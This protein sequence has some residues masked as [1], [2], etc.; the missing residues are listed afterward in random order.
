MTWPYSSSVTIPTPP[1]ILPATAGSSQKGYETHGAL[2]TKMATSTSP[3]VAM[4]WAKLP[5]P[6]TK[7]R[8]NKTMTEPVIECDPEPIQAT[9]AMIHPPITPL[10]KTLEDELRM[11]SSP[12]SASACTK[13][14]RRQFVRVE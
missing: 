12:S 3:L 13:S 6:T 2:P 9:V 7:V 10:Q 8:S 14:G 11:A 4:Q 1:Q 5:R